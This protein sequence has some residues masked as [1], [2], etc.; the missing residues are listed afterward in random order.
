MMKVRLM[1]GALL[2]TPAVLVATATSG[3]A[4]SVQ[5]AVAFAGRLTIVPGGSGSTNVCFSAVRCADGVAAGAVLAKPVTGMHG[6][7]GYT[8]GC[9]LSVPYAPTGVGELDVRFSDLSGETPE[10]NVR[11]QRFGQIA[12]LTGRNGYVVGGAAVVAPAPKQAAVP[13]CGQQPI[14]LVVTGAM[15]F[16]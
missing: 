8:E 16:A 11:W 7:F 13:V 4:A 12:V 2:A 14:D 15:A 3:H 10:V 6:T 5:G 1:V 9:T